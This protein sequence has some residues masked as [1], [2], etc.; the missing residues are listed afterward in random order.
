MYAQYLYDSH[1][2]RMKK[3]VRRPGGAVEVTHYVSAMFEYHHWTP[4]MGTGTPNPATQNNHVHVLDDSRRV[5]L[6]RIGP[7][8]P[9]D[10]GPAVAVQL[11]DH[12]GSSVAVL[13]GP[14]ELTNREE[15]TPTARPVSAATPAKR[16]RYTGKE[17]DEE[18]G[19]NYH[20]ARYLNLVL[21]RADVL[22]TRTARRRTRTS[23]GS[24]PAPRCASSIRP[25][26]T[27]GRC[28]GLR[29]A[30]SRSRRSAI[31]CGR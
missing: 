1:G 10:K 28:S 2:E 4:P 20:A 12:L 19:L 7:A 25:A 5:A 21:A 31:S 30:T 8:H 26:P 3:L 14:G 22:L 24:P 23:T 27:T 16:H 18:S 17:R 9:D 11:A 13:D 15:Y 29:P 6:V